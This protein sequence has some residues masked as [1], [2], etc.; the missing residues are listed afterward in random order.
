MSGMARWKKTL[1]R[2]LR[3]TDPRNYRYE[4]AAAILERLG[5]VKAPETSGTSHKQWRHVT[6]DGKVIYV[7]LVKK[8]HG[9]LKPYL[10]RD[11][12]AALKAGGLLPDDIQEG[13]APAVKEEAD[14]AMD[15]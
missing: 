11:M 10:I 15:K 14:N 1:A 4:E 5:F 6:R 8:G 9:T 7:G 3:D 12:L 2:M 13:L